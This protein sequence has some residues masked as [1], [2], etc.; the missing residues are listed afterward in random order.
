MKTENKKCNVTQ[1]IKVR[2]TFLILSDEVDHWVDLFSSQ[3][4]GSYGQITL[5]HIK[6]LDVFLLKVFLRRLF[7][8]DG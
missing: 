7:Q 1:S 5:K 2:I 8:T 4:M 6:K 3:N